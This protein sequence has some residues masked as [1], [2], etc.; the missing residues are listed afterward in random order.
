[1]AISKDKKHVK[2]RGNAG[3]RKSQKDC[4]ESIPDTP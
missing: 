3:W 2:R 1:M 4:F